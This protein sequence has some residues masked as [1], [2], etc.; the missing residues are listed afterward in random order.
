[1]NTTNRGKRICHKITKPILAI[2]SVST[3]RMKFF[4]SS[5]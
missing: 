3:R 2:A 1:L 5:A 4:L